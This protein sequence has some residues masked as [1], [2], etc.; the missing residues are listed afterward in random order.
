MRCNFSHLQAMI[1]FDGP[2]FHNTLN[3]LVNNKDSMKS[4]L[5]EVQP[6]R[7]Y[8]NWKEPKLV[9]KAEAYDVPRNQCLIDFE[10]A[11]II[12]LP[13]PQNLT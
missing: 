3:R 5:R 6:F 9:P 1:M 4:A 12:P 11:K 7:I 8:V 10:F 2:Y 13:F